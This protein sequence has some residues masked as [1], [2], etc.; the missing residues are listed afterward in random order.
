MKIFQVNEISQNVEHDLQKIFA[1]F[2]IDYFTH[3]IGLIERARKKFFRPQSTNDD[4]V[5]AQQSDYVWDPEWSHPLILIIL[6]DISSQAISTITIHKDYVKVFAFTINAT[7]IYCK[8]LKITIHY[9]L[10]LHPFV[11][12]RQ[13][14]SLNSTV[15][16]QENLNGTRN[17]TQQD[18]QT[19]SYFI[20]EE[21]VKTIATTT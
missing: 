20:K 3:N 7:L 1:W 10:K 16:Q 15:I 18:I 8:S 2:I 14:N 4:T 11:P 9:T 5:I 19:N 12:D 6:I 21:I 13:N 17:L